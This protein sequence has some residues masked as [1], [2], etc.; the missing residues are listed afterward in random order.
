MVDIII[1]G[2]GAGGLIWRFY[3]NYY[4]DEVGVVMSLVT[5]LFLTHVAYIITVLMA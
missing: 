2:V 4:V 3:L 1:H 5:W